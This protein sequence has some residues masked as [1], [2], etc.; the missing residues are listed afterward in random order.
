MDGHIMIYGYIS[1]IQDS[2]PGKWGE[3]NLKSVKSQ[4][5]SQPEADTFVVHI[6]SGGGDVNE[7]FAIHDVLKATGKKIITQ[8]EGMCASIA[9]VV[10]LAG[11]ERYMTENSEFMIHCP[12]MFGG[13]TAED[14]QYQADELQKI[15]D[16]VLDFYVTK[17]GSDR[18]AIK[19]MMKAETW[20]TSEQAKSLGFIT[21]VMA[22]MK[23]VATLNHKTDMSK[24][25]TSEEFDKKWEEKSNG[26]FDKIM[27]LVRGKVKMITLTTADGT[28]LDFGDAVEDESQI[29]VGTTATVDGSP[30]NGEYVLTDGR[31]LVFENGAVT[32]I[33]EAEMEETVDSLK[34]EL[35]EKDAKIAELEAAK[36]ESDEK[37]VTMTKEVGT[38]QEDFK[39][40]KAEMKT[41]L[42]IQ[43]PKTRKSETTEQEARKPFK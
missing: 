12:M 23:A 4:I 5:E 32:E 40:F 15:E 14:L 33:M 11:S 1:S 25:M 19:A 36:A 39:K 38:L 30:A 28:I 24:Q 8:I 34:A 43:D 29:V 22:T 31:T 20:L 3:V 35:A 2:D 18:E 16:K 42:G 13:G 6:N 41:D 17:T 26:F 7:G 37:L 21:E 10:A 27:K 9:T